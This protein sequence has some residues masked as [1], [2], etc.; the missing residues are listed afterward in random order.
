MYVIAI[1][2][3]LILLQSMGFRG[4][5]F[6][7][8]WANFKKGIP[9]A[10]SRGNRRQNTETKR[11]GF[12]PF[13]GE[14]PNI[15]ENEVKTDAFRFPGRPLGNGHRRFNFGEDDD[16]IVFNDDEFNWRRPFATSKPSPF[17][18]QPPNMPRQP[19]LFPDIWDR[20][21]T[22]PLPPVSSTFAI[23]GMETRRPICEENCPTTPEY[24]PVCADDNLTYSN[25]GRFNCAVRC[26]KQ[27]KIQFR[28]ACQARGR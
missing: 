1:S 9:M 8:D 15:E 11:W 16:S 26:G 14:Q 20:S 3:F 4:Q 19:S 25:I 28:G 22:T 12:P 21:T 24:N 18:K 5:E 10:N 13:T 7:G 27:I 2:T 23:P 6:S 17:P